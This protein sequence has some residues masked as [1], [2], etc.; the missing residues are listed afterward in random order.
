MLVCLLAVAKEEAAEDEGK[1][2]PEPQ[3]K[4]GQHSCEGYLGTQQRL[5][6]DLAGKNVKHV[7]NSA[8]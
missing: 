8:R 5:A 2:D 3:T 6:L 4:E 1:G 7:T